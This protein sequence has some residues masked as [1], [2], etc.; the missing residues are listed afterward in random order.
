MGVKDIP[1]VNKNNTIQRRIKIVFKRVATRLMILF[2]VLLITGLVISSISYS[3]KKLELVQDQSVTIPEVSLTQNGSI[4]SSSF[5]I[6][7]GYFTQIIIHSENSHLHWKLYAKGSYVNLSDQTVRYN[8]D[9]KSGNTNSTNYETFL[10][11][12]NLRLISYATYY[13][14][15]VNGYDKPQNVTVSVNVL[16]PKDVEIY[17]FLNYVGIPM[18]ISGIIG[19]AIEMTRNSNAIY[20]R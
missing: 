16:S 17:G 1:V 8:I 5:G 13:L 6:L 9:I 2:I 7:Y 14:N 19:L 10:N 18:I 3:Y 15:V 12:S 4:N 11:D 20:S